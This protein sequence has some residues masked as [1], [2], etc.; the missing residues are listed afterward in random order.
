MKTR[1]DLS[2]TVHNFEK[3]NLVTISDKTGFYDRYRCKRCWI[4]GK[5]FGT[6]SSVIVEHSM[7]DKEKVEFCFL[8]ELEL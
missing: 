8:S 7:E 4:V 2:N 5:R 6:S 1:I 3:T